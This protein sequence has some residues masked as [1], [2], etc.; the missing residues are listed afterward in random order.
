MLYAAGYYCNSPRLFH[1]ESGATGISIPSS[2]VQLK[3]FISS[4]TCIVFCPPTMPKLKSALAFHQAHQARLNAQAKAGKVKEDKE[5]SLRHGKFKKKAK[6]GP[7]GK[8]DSKDMDGGVDHRAAGK[9]HG[10]SARQTGT[11]HGPDTAHA[12][13]TA[14]RVGER[15]GESSTSAP[16]SLPGANGKGKAKA[17]NRRPT[18]PIDRDD[19]VLLLGE[20]NFSFAMALISP[21]H[22]HPPRLVCAT[23]YDSEQV[24]TILVF[25][26]LVISTIWHLGGSLANGFFDTYPITAQDV[27]LMLS[28]TCYIKYPDARSNVSRLREAGVKVGFGVDAGA[29][30]KSKG[31]VGKGRRWSRVVFNFPHV[32]ECSVPA[33]HLGHRPHIPI[34]FYC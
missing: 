19:T 18:N 8:P 27:M 23:S 15:H 26:V 28:Q 29:L 30:E 9:D 32:G 34:P 4:A 14:L 22:S 16:A 1:S 10:G 31:A 11:T 33:V 17:S 5:R 2:A 25:H 24:S 12:S 13:G 3:C 21:P 6:V 20:A 7:M